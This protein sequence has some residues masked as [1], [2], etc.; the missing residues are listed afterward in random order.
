[1]TFI[2]IL[3]ILA[4]AAFLATMAVR[5]VPHYVQY[6]TVKSVMDGLKHDPDVLGG[7]QEAILKTIDN[8]LYINEVRNVP[9]N[10]FKLKRVPNGVELSVS[11]EVREPILGNLDAL[12]TFAHQVTLTSK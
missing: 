3:L 6:A 7:G 11:Y 1:M 5:L 8:K 10:Y 2:G 9:R 4:A 12:M